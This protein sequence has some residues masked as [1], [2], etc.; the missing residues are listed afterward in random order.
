MEDN[1]YLHNLANKFV[2]DEE[3]SIT[4]LL[5]IKG[6][7]NIITS[8]L[9]GSHLKI[10]A[11]KGDCLW[12]S[13]TVSNTSVVSDMMSFFVRCEALLNEPLNYQQIDIQQNIDVGSKD[14]DKLDRRASDMIY[15]V[16]NYK[17]FEQ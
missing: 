16:S 9:E 5:E 8:I 3:P 17:W 4:R 6:Y 15:R 11:S 13:V 2:R 14:W 10:T 7:E 1:R 12:I